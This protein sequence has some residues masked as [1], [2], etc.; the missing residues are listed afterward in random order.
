MAGEDH[1]LCPVGNF[2]NWDPDE[3]KAYKW[4]SKDPT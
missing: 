1:I 2:H 4:L 3:V